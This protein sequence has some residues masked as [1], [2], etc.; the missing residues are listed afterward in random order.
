MALSCWS[1]FKC[2]L[3][4]KGEKSSDFNKVFFKNILIKKA[5]SY[6]QN[7]LIMITDCCLDDR[8]Y[9]YWGVFSLSRDSTTFKTE[10]VEI[11]HWS[12][13]ATINCS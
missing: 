6:A 7:T 2:I 1:Q 9:S 10:M 13:S 11:N 8:L 5:Y 4:K 3:R 12:D